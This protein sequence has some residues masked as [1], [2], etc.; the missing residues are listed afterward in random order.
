MLILKFIKTN[1]CP[2]ISFKVQEICHLSSQIIS[3]AFVD[4]NG[5][6]E[7]AVWGLGGHLLNVHASVRAG[8]K[9]R[10]IVFSVGWKCVT[11]SL[12]QIDTQELIVGIL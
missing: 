6:C 8:N 11:P 5:E 1:L 4:V 12:H 2:Q 7:E 10:P 9:H 3:Y